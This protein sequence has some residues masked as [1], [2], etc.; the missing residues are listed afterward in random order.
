MWSPMA[1]VRLMRWDSVKTLHDF[2]SVDSRF[3][4]ALKEKSL[5]FY[6]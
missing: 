5:D 6:A 3:A 1:I 2:E 4:D